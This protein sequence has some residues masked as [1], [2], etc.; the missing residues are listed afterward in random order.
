MQMR[1]EGGCINLL[2][3]SPSK[4]H[5]RHQKSLN[6]KTVV[7]RVKH[8]IFLPY[9]EITSVRQEW[10]QRACWEA[11]VGERCWWL[12]L[13]GLQCRWRE[14]ESFRSCLG[15]GMRAVEDVRRQAS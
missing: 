11:G 12:E 4:D 1:L 6:R 14:V 8:F 7:C 5:G 13:C 10:I 15:S 2:R 3:V 9:G